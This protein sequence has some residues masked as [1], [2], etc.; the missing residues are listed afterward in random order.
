M[1]LVL[2][3]L[4]LFHKWFP[5]CIYILILFNDGLKI[6]CGQRKLHISSAVIATNVITRMMNDE[7]RRYARKQ[8]HPNLIK[9]SVR[10]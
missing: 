8:R 1:S 4:N 2:E 3:L 5:H 7:A 10:N 6:R 9:V